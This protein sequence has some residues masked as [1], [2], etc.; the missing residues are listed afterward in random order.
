MQIDQTVP[1][2]IFG[3]VIRILRRKSI[4]TLPEIRY[5]ITR[6]NHAYNEDNIIPS[7]HSQ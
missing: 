7:S 1:V 4:G 5:G 2:R 3:R 6:Q